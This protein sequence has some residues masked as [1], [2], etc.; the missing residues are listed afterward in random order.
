MKTGK[1]LELSVGKLIVGD[2]EVLEG[3]HVG[4]EEG[5]IAEVSVK[6]LSG[7]YGEKVDLE[8][9]VVMPGLIDAHVHIKY[10]GKPDPIEHTDEYLTIR[11]VELA[12]RALMS[13]CTSLADAG[14][15]RNVAFA[16]RNAINDGVVLGPR[17]FVCG[18]MITMTG[19]RSTKP[20]MR[21]EVDGPDSARKAARQLLMYYGADFIKLGAT[22]AISSPHTG[23]RHPQLTVEEMKAC[24][25]E[26]HNCA[27][28]VHAHCYG[29]QGITNAIEAGADVIV[30]GQSLTD[31]HIASMR[32]RGMML[33]PTL[34]TYW[35]HYEHWVETGVPERTV[36][37]GI[38]DLTEAN[39]KKAVR[40]GI[41]FAMGTDSGMTDNFFGDNPKDLEY[42]VKWGITPS[43][44]IIAGTMD[45]ARSLA[46]ENKLGSIEEGKLAD[47]LVLREDPTLDITAIRTSLERIMLNGRFVKG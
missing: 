26:A 41:P 12:R 40:E 19:G 29:E 14:A 28:K 8:D 18:E 22:G 4:V 43:K 32:G 42:M 21:M 30:H 20:G 38:W 45:A 11:G 34:K 2:G 5:K 25:E 10:T 35:G 46:I 31:A 13:G 24:V 27:K 1:S 7:E 47:L 9:F 23:P 33:M 36:T 3:V 39:F 6:G 17:L 44:A 16:A 15:V 37:S